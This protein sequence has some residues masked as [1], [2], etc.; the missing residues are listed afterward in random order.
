MQKTCIVLLGPTA[1]G[2]TD[3][4]IQL[5]QHFATEIIS[6]DS[7]QC[8]KELNIGVAKPTALQLNQV[9]HHFINSH[10][11]H[12]LLSA[13]D[14]ENYALNAIEAVF[15]KN[16]IALVVGGTGL[17]IKALC[18]GLDQIPAVAENIRTEIIHNYQLFGID[19][20]IQKVQEEDAL[21]VSNGEMKNPQRIM[22]ALEVKR[23]TGQSI[24]SFQTQLK[25]QRPF[26]IIKIG[27]QIP[28]EILYQRI[29]T[30]VDLMLD[31]GLVDEVSQL[32]AHQNLNA[33]QTVGYSE[34]FDYLNGKISFDKAVERIKQ[35]TRHYAKRQMT[36]FARD[37]EITWLPPDFSD[38]LQA[39]EIKRNE[40]SKTLSQK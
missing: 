23:S 4:T 34:L 31:A 39:I 9:H 22:R 26:H 14:F 12:Q 27:L 19:W 8:Y 32:Q 2:K 20:L 5:A 6:A 29:N 3:A 36:W 11:I 10:S 25:K 37:A 21:F 1:I 28:R 15:E 17:Y 24:I 16:D 30:R 33:L 38:I 35:N 18:E 7:R 13:A 40:L